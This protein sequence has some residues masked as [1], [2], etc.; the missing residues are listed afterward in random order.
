VQL[1]QIK[2]S[3]KQIIKRFCTRVVQTRAPLANAAALFDA[4]STICSFLSRHVS[5]DRS[6]RLTVTDATVARQKGRRC[7]NA[8]NKEHR[9]MQRHDG[10]IFETSGE[11][12]RERERMLIIFHKYG[13][14]FIK[15]QVTAGLQREYKFMP[16]HRPR[17]GGIKKIFP[18]F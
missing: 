9:C 8:K 2:L 18:S 12:E 14:K 5:H 6:D 11:R 13:R 7:I 16:W 17:R 3:A 10:E 15:H 4:V 1:F